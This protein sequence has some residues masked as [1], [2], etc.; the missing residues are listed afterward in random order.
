LTLKRSSDRIPELFDKVVNTK[1]V[2]SRPPHRAEANQPFSFFIGKINNYTR[3][4]VIL[5]QRHQ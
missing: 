3:K 5:W 1:D 4:K 2:G